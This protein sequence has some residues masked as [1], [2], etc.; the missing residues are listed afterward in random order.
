MMLL[1]GKTLPVVE[2]R[3]LLEIQLVVILVGWFLVRL[4]ELLL[5][6]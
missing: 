3:L 1:K 6:D 5:G 4:E 2:R